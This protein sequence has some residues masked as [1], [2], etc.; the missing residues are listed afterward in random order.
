MPQKVKPPLVSGG[1]AESKV[2]DRSSAG[3]GKKILAKKDSKTEILKKGEEEKEK[4]EKGG[5]A[6]DPLVMVI[7][8]YIYIYI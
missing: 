2:P 8:I 1:P 5:G 3:I 6:N 4:K 7:Y